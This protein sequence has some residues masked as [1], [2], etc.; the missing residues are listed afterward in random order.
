VTKSLQRLV[1]T[2]GGP[3]MLAR[4]GIMRALNRHVPSEARQR[5]FDTSG[6]KT[7]WGKRKLARDR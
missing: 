4:I 2:T 1:A 5:P 6:E 7:H 3:T